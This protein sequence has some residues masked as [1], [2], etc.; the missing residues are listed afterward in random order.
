MIR[1]IRPHPAIWRIRPLQAVVALTLLAGLLYAVP[2]ALAQPSNDDF[3]YA[4]PI[5]ELP[6]SVTQDTSDATQASDDVSD[7]CGNSGDTSVWFSFSPTTMD[8]P[9]IFDL[10]GTDYTNEWSIFTGPRGELTNLA[11]GGFGTNTFGFL[12]AQGVTYHIRISGPYGGGTLVLEARQGPTVQTLTIDGIASV[13][14]AT[15]V[16]TVSGKITCD[17][18]STAN[19]SGTLRQRVTRF[20]VIHGTFS[21]TAPCLANT[22]AW[23]TTVV[24]ENG[25][26]GPGRGGVDASATACEGYL[27]CTSKSTSQNVKLRP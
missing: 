4:T 12:A 19:V 26:F 6:F 25:P 20:V 11:C 5:D 2:V 7:P 27:V 14:H 21:V 24:G 13:N 3:D 18:D 22:S 23:S 15:G 16:A 17:S 10:T 9:F 8:I 1:N